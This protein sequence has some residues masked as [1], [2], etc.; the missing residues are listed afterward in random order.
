M[1]V[2][3]HFLEDRKA[4]DGESTGGGGIFA[5]SLVSASFGAEILPEDFDT[6]QLRRRFS[7]KNSL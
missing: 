2:P 3:F 7:S 1:H 4:K 6:V 5:A